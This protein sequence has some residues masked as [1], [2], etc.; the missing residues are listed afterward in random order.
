MAKTRTQTQQLPV[1][2]N[3]YMRA[4]A[5]AGTFLGL[6]LGMTYWTHS[7]D[8]AHFAIAAIIVVFCLLI[9]GVMGRIVASLESE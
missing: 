3:M 7:M 1:D 8:F 6:V 2:Q 5:G 4:G 9:G